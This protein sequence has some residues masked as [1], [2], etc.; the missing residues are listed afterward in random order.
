MISAIVVWG[1]VLIGRNDG[2]APS[3]TQTMTK[4]RV[5]DLERS[6]TGYVYSQQQ[7]I[8]VYYMRYTN[9]GSGRYYH[10]PDT[11]HYVVDAVAPVA[12]VAP[13]TMP[14]LLIPYASSVDVS[15]AEK[16][17]RQETTDDYGDQR[18]VQH[19][20][21]PVTEN[22]PAKELLRFHPRTDDG[23]RNAFEEEHDDSYDSVE[24]EDEIPEQGE[25]SE[26]DDNEEIHD[27][28]HS[29]KMNVGGSY[30][31]SSEAGDG[32][33]SRHG[34][35]A[36]KGYKKLEEF[37]KGERGIDSNE[38]QK[39]YYSNSGEHDE[40]HVDEAETYG[41]HEEAENDQEGSDYGRSSYRNKGH[42]TNGFHNVYCKD[43]YKKKTDFYDDD[44]K[45]GFSDKYENFEKD[46]KADE[47][48]SKKGGRRSSGNDRQDRGKK[49]YYVKGHRESQDQGHAN[50]EAEKSYRADRENYS[51]DESSNSN[52]VQKFEND[53]GHR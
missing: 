16:Q 25:Q 45:K 43:E 2:A 10:A 48:N 35:K 41:S 13:A 5:A 32:E 42:K 20:D 44:H 11:V 39:G 4:M 3:G 51:V 12:H 40:G 26:H 8:P 46:Y 53:S 7:G 49:G 9:H 28:D 38:N 14:P 30:D 23:T 1:L 36:A 47:G 19:A 33:Y 24:Q 17:T 52:Q 22:I 37:E 50:E 31:G 18:S 27:V 21:V 29:T 15:Q 34:E 6:A